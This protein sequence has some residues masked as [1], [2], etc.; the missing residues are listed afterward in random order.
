M[1][2]DL[3]RNRDPKSVLG[4]FDGQVAA[5]AELGAEHYFVTTNMDYVPTLPSLQLPHALFLHADMRYGTDDP[6]LWPQQWTA[7][8]CHLPVIAKK[9]SRPEIDVMWW[10]PLPAN[11]IVGSA[12][13]QGLGRL[14]WKRISNF[15]PPSTTWSHSSNS[16]LFGELINNILMWTEQLQTLPTTYNKMVFAVTWLQH[17]FLELDVLYRTSI[18]QCVG[19]FTTVPSVAQQLCTACLPFGFLRPT[20]VFDAENI[21]AVVPLWEPERGFIVLHTPGDGALPIVYSRNSASE[22]I[23]AIHRVAVLT[24]WYHDPFETS[25]SRSLSPPPVTQPSAAIPVASS[26]VASS[27]REVSQWNNQQPRFKPYPPKAPGKAA[28]KGPAKIARDKFSYLAVEEM[29]PSIVAWADALAQVD[30]SITPF[31]TDPADRCYILPEP[32]LFGF[33]VPRQSL[34]EFSL[35]QTR[36]IVWQVAKASFRFEFSV[37]DRRVSKKDRVDEV[38]LVSQA[39]S[40]RG[41]V[42]T[43]MEDCHRYAIR[44]ATLMLDWTMKSPRLNIICRVTKRLPWSP[45]QMQ[46]LEITVCRYYTQAF[47]EYFGRAAVVPM[48]LEHDVEKEDRQFIY[49]L[50]F[51]VSGLNVSDVAWFRP[52]QARLHPANLDM[53]RDMVTYKNDSSP[54]VVVRFGLCSAERTRAKPADFDMRPDMVTQG[55]YASDVPPKVVM[56]FGLRSAERTRAE[57]TD[58]G[59][60]PDLVTHKNDPLDVPLKVVMHFGLR[61]AGCVDA[62]LRHAARLGDIQSYIQDGFD[63]PP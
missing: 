49:F 63:E 59:M 16:P 10:D 7:R 57:P 44:A 35:E 24:P 11:F 26:S 23:T 28:A 60:R 41:W 29:L 54:K 37:L 58:L 4:P 42:A 6:T 19:A 51:L 15:L 61:S 50:P 34:P 39:M 22:K 31:T 17:A 55:T 47:W 48:H 2:L 53:V 40:K 43:A 38:G 33:P 14:Y 25:D 13:T 20:Y 46:E 18:V 5:F 21:L 27:S 3:L 32:A 8:Y 1:A 56:H 45:S 30:Q 12:V 9:G 36:E 52:P 62:E